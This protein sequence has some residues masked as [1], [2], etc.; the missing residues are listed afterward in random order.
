MI[1]YLSGEVVQKN[2][3]NLIIEVNN[4]G[5]QVYSSYFVIEAARINQPTKVF[6]YEIIKEDSYDLYGF[7]NQLSLELFEKLISVK[8]IGPRVAIGIL[9]VA[10]P[11]EII[12]AISEGNTN[13]LMMAKGIGKRAAEQIVVE[14]RGKLEDSDKLGS[15]NLINGFNQNEEV[16]QALLALGYSQKDALKLLSKVDKTKDI[17]EQVKDALGNG[18]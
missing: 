16:V 6:I 7:D 13:F 18:L 15:I 2:V 14:L 3:D 12:Q 4:I 1:A 9:N 10:K 8:N 17:Q 5:Y 11:N